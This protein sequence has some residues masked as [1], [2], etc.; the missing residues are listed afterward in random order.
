ME[1]DSMSFGATGF[2]S[3]GCSAANCNFNVNSG[4]FKTDSVRARASYQFGGP[5]VAK[6]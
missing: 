2:G 5:I 6:Y 3:A 1:L 4:T